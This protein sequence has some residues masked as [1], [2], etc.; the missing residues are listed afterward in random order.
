MI[1][2]V[3]GSTQAERDRFMKSISKMSREELDGLISSI[4]ATLTLQSGVE[5]I[6]QSCIMGCGVCEQVG[7][8]VGARFEGLTG[9]LM[10]QKQQLDDIAA[11]YTIQHYKWAEQML[12]AQGQLFLLLTSTALRVHNTNSIN[13]IHLA[14]QQAMARQNSD[15]TVDPSVAEKYDTL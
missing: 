8:L 1:D 6:R 10:E 11:M 15:D 12:D 7:P 2:D 14:Q 5:M 9:A 4:K 3:A 13:D